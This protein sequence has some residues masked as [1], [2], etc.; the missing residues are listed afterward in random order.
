MAHEKTDKEIINKTHNTARFF[1]EVRQIS[2]VL[3]VGVLLWGAFAYF[4]MPQRKD[5]EIAVRQA[6]AIT[7][8]PGASA[9]KTS[10]CAP[11]LADGDSIRAR[12]SIDA[13]KGSS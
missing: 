8:W 11:R 7:P 2:W 6:V 5:P 1:V 12:R 3:L 9:E 10:H 4:S 13:T